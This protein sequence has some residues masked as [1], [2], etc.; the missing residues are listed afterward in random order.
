MPKP[1]KS[2]REQRASPASQ[3]AGRCTAGRTNTR[4]R[5][6]SLSL[7]S[8]T[9]P[10]EN[11]L[12]AGFSTRNTL[13]LR[14]SLSYLRSHHQQPIDA[15]PYHL[16]RPRDESGLASGPR[17]ALRRPRARRR[18]RHHPE[19]PPHPRPRFRDSNGPPLL[20]DQCCSPAGCH[21]AVL[22]VLRPP[23]CRRRRLILPAAIDSAL[24][25]QCRRHQPCL[26]TIPTT[27]TLII[28]TINRPAD[29]E[30][31]TPS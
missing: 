19:R 6:R 14:S 31:P 13:P 12:V 10:Q 7:N 1:R 24:D 18:E 8:R 11:D 29:I 16:R 9:Q 28:R 21:S 25:L 5:L 23:F 22:G 30:L 17:S 2:A 20:P 26:H 4:S 15:H 27:D 3:P